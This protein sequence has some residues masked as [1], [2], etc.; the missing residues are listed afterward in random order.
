VIDDTPTIALS[1]GVERL[2][3]P[4][5]TCLE[6][7]P[8]ELL[9]SRYMLEDVIGRGGACI[10][11]RARDLDRSSPEDR[12]ANLV[13]LKVLRCEQRTNP[14]AL[15]H[16]QREFRQM[17]GLSHPG[18]AQVFDLECDGEIWF[19]SM[20][21]VAGRT[22]KGWMETPGSCADALR[23][24]KSCCEALDHAHSLGV[25]HADLKPTNVMVGDDGAVTLID[26]GCAASPGSAEAAGRNPLSTLTPLYASPQVLAGRAA[27]RR[28]D[29]F[30]LACLS[31]AMLSGGRHPFGGRPA[32]EDGRAKCAPTYV[33]V[34]PPGL[35]EVIERGLSADPEVRPA[36]VR[37]FLQEM[38]QA[39]ASVS[40]PALPRVFKQGVAGAP[41][42]MRNRGSA[43][44]PAALSTVADIFGG[45][46]V[47]Y[48]HSQPVVRLSALAF[49]V[50][51]AAVLLP[52]NNRP[53]AIR[54]VTL[55]PEASAAA[56]PV[57]PTARLPSEPIP[58]IRALPHDSGVIS[59]ESPTLRASAVQSL[60]AISVRR[61]QATRGRGTF[62][63]RVER[64]TA[65]PGVDYERM[66]PQRVSFAEGQAVRTLFI[67]LISSSETLIAHAP[68]TFTVALE[69]VAGGPALG[70]FARVTVAID[71]PPSSG[72]LA[73]YQA[74]AR[75]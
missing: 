26:F 37:Q 56:A 60:V 30:S 74:R 57:A 34:I 44:A 27:E 38:L 12:A 53:Q 50:V 42:V 73:A 24:I 17:Q 7:V 64:G 59:F 10:V 40:H 21:L 28:D 61:L 68:R 35:F 48:R 36:S 6:P 58:G 13:A 45:G 39:A 70:R 14:L 1:P 66:Q 11:F 2:A 55:L 43:R 52:L 25:L 41:R 75:E 67:P 31:Y 18:I 51:S 19:M 65:Y 29:V 9:R 3:A 22:V 63:W 69:Q 32:L 15:T 49:A 16:L 71:P 46:R 5:A 72:R 4:R 54:T 8:G 33:R 62:L 23:I 20:Q 47:T